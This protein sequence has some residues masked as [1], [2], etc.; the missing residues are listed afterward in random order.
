[1]TSKGTLD[2]EQLVRDLATAGYAVT[3]LGARYRVTNPQ[4][5]EA[6]FLPRRLPK[7]GRATT[8][9]DIERML[10]KIGFSPE[11]AEQAR[12]KDRQRRLEQARKGG[13]ALLAEAQRRADALPSP[14]E[15]QQM[16]RQRVSPEVST[17]APGE[18]R[19]EIMVI[20]ADFAA[21]LLRH[22][23]YYDPQGN[24]TGEEGA[25]RTN[26][27]FSQQRAETYRDNILRGEWKLTHQGIALDTDGLLVDGQHRLVGLVMASEQDPNVSIRTMVT[28]DLAPEAFDAVDQGRKR[29]VADVLGARGE[30]NALGLASVV[31]IVLFYDD[32][33]TPGEWRS[34]TISTERA[35]RKVEEEPGIR[36][37]TRWGALNNIALPAAE[38]AARHVILRGCSAERES[39]AEDFFTKYRTGANVGM[40][41][42]ALTLRNTI[43]SLRSNAKRKQSGLEHFALIIKAWNA[44][45]AGRQVKS[46]AWRA[47]E[48]VPRATHLG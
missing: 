48:E 23:R 43:L 20:D 34:A 6:V 42:P 30:K 39:F 38:G 13:D 7:N 45:V 10:T 36:E 11:Q 2:I 44:E 15:V 25:A 40:F 1:M 21:E 37:A 33:R 22:N 26:R 18:P 41:A 17:S 28:Y 24:L 9:A 47:T 4:G 5:G 46:L 16:I 3:L 12:E 32:K 27:P 19:T 14:A 35:H 8:I 29:T 31:R